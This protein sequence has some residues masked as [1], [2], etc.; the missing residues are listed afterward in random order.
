MYVPV[1]V[2]VASQTFAHPQ[3]YYMFVTS[4]TLAYSLVTNTFTHT[5]T[6][7]VYSGVLVYSEK[8][9]PQIKQANLTNNQPLPSWLCYTNTTRNNSFSLLT[10]TMATYM[11]II[12][13]S[14]TST[15]VHSSEGG[16]PKY[17]G[18]ETQQSSTGAHARDSQTSRLY[19]HVLLNSL[20]TK[21]LPAVSPCP[22]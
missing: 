11:V 17:K 2:L 16:P 9:E 18:I 14:L 1:Q 21:G 20:P 10:V 7:Y 3:T 13:T 22:T 8:K 12:D 6:L 15:S 4:Q 19:R 5:H